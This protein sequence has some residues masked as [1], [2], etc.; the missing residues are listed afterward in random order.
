M[1]SVPVDTLVGGQRGQRTVPAAPPC[2]A[3]VGHVGV[4]EGA[5]DGPGHPIG[6]CPGDPFGIGMDCD[7]DGA[8]AFFTALLRGAG[9]EAFA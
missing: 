8:H 2:D 6:N 5:H 7:R 4:C 3:D 1:H 9:F